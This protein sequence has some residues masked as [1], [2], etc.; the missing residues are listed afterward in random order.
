MPAFQLRLPG[1]QDRGRS[2][3]VQALEIRRLFLP[4]GQVSGSVHRLQVAGHHLSLLPATRSLLCLRRARKSCGTQT[5]GRQV[6]QR[7]RHQGRHEKVD[8][9]CLPC[10]RPNWRRR[11]IRTF[12][13][14]GVRSGERQKDTIMPTGQ[15]TFKFFI[16]V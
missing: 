3:I 10:R 15:C 14:L 16:M 9:L 6:L 7:S 2:K 13:F 12:L 5:G 1:R 11:I 4:A 8:G